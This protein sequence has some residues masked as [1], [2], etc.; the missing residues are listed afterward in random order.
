MR[1]QEHE[2]LTVSIQRSRRSGNYLILGG[3]AAALLSFGPAF[4]GELK[5]AQMRGYSASGTHQ[6]GSDKGRSCIVTGSGFSN[7]NDATIVLRTRDCCPT[8]PQGGTSS[9]FTL[10]YC[11]PDRGP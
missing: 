10:N 2:I 5:L 9:G 4:A 7:C 6:C 1:A 3:A 11:I 8:T